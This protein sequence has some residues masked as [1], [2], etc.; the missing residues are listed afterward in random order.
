MINKILNL[1]RKPPK[2]VENRKWEENPARVGVFIRAEANKPRRRRYR[3]V[4][5]APWFGGRFKVYPS[6]DEKPYTLK[7]EHQY[8][9]VELKFKLDTLPKEFNADRA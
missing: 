6:T 8:L 2:L 3:P 1:F 7:N 4:Y 9:Y 5:I